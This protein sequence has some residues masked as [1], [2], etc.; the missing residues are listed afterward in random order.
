MYISSSDP[1]S[2]SPPHRGLNQVQSRSQ[3]CLPLLNGSTEDEEHRKDH[4][5]LQT[6]NG[7]PLN[8]CYFDGSREK[9]Y[10]LKSLS[11]SQGMLDIY[12]SLESLQKHK[13]DL[14]KQK[15]RSKT[16]DV[17]PIFRHLVQSSSSASLGS[18]SSS[19]RSRDFDDMIVGG[20]RS[21]ERVDNDDDV[22]KVV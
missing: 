10:G 1:I 3:A 16:E 11:K 18:A 9:L 17:L 7:K 20:D 22:T 5:H 6:M 13:R 2:F 12:R 15:E 4:R 21:V 19:A 14:L 8:A